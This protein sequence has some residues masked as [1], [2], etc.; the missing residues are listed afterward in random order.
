[1]KNPFVIALTAALITAGAIKAAP[2]LAEPAQPQTFVS[3]VRTADLDLASEQGRR[4]LQQRLERAAREVCGTPSD[5]DLVGKNNVRECRAEAV[6]KAAGQQE[7]L[8]ASANRGRVI[9]VTASR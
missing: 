5:L 2:A 7:A 1:M 8:V 4:Q 6:A 9:A 3:H